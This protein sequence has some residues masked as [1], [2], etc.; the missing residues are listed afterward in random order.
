M[1]M[2][3]RMKLMIGLLL[4]FFLLPLLVGQLPVPDRGKTVAKPVENKQVVYAAS[5]LTQ[6]DT[7]QSLD[8]PFRALVFF[9]HTH[10]A[11]EPIVKNVSGKVAVSDSKTNILSLQDMIKSHFQLNGIATDVLEVDNM[12]AMKD[13]G[14][15]YYQA[16]DTMRTFVKKR[17]EEQQ[18]D[19][20]IDFHRDSAKRKTTTITHNGATYA[21]IVLVI[22]NEHKNYRWNLAYAEKLSASLNTIVPDISRGVISKGGDGVDGKYNQDLSKSL[23]LIEL[24]GI[25]NNKEELNRTIAVL[26]KAIANSF[27]GSEKT[28]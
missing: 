25:E 11:Y 6:K 3:K 23:L 26:A 20:A 8:S 13:Q 22:G 15:E 12:K 27:K 16:Y 21:R 14:K 28:L 18:Y 10:E 19:L 17:F 4:F 7:V 1:A 24:G 5:E 2:V 9:T